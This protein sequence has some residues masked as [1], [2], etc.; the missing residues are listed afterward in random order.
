MYLFPSKYI[1]EMRSPS[2]IPFPPLSFH[3]FS[4]LSFSLNTLDIFLFSWPSFGQILKTPS[5][6]LLSNRF[7]MAFLC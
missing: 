2:L 7:E 3:L 1:H 4:F 6:F 5:H